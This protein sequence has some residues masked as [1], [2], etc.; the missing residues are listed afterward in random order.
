MITIKGVYISTQLGK[1]EGRVYLGPSK[2]YGCLC[3][4]QARYMH[5]SIGGS[6]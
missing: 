3:P 5:T 2:E 6:K 4:I 1:G